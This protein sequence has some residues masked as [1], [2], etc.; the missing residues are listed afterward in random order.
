MNQQ[1]LIEEINKIESCSLVFERFFGY[2]PNDIKER[3][4]YILKFNKTLKDEKRKLKCK[5]TFK[6]EKKN[7]KQTFLK[8]HQ[9][10][11]HSENKVYKSK[12]LEKKIQQLNK[13]K[14]LIDTKINFLKE[15]KES[16]KINK[17]KI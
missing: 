1:E 4:Q 16:N 2:L 12:K 7:K 17:S 3:K 5:K 14:Q 11:D 8:H 9:S 13:K 6:G 10:D 15:I